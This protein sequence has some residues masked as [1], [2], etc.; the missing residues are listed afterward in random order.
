MSHVWI[1]EFQAH[2]KQWVPSNDFDTAYLTRKEALKFLKKAGEKA[3][4][5]RVSKYCRVGKP[6]GK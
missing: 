3:L 4:I 6:E 5:Y 2:G 1:I